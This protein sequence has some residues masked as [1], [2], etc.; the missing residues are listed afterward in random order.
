VELG[1]AAPISKLHKIGAA[2]LRALSSTSLELQLRAPRCKIKKKK[3]KK[4][5]LKLWRSRFRKKAPAPVLQLPQWCSCSR[6]GALAMAI[7]G[8]TLE[9]GR[10]GEVGGGRRVGRGEM[11]WGQSRGGRKN[12]YLG[13]PDVV[14]VHPQNGLNG[15]ILNWCIG[16]C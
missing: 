10:R 8:K 11:F 1:A 14:L 12:I 9:V 4:L 5:T 2:L 15:L 3:G 6:C 16:G 13:N 7:G